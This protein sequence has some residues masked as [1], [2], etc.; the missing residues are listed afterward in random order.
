MADVKPT[1]VDRF[2]PVVDTL[3]QEAV[4][5]REPSSNEHDSES[6]VLNSYRYSFGQ[7][8]HI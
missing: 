6:S 4:P 2:L 1:T 7:S 8:I 3:V 5:A